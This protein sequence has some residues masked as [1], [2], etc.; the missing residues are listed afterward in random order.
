MLYVALKK[1]GTAQAAAK[2]FLHTRT[3]FRVSLTGSVGV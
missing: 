1:T 2:C 3:T